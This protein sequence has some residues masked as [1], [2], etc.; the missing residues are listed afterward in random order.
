MKV[1][2]RVWNQILILTS[3]YVEHEMVM[4]LA[5]LSDETIKRNDSDNF[6]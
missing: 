2:N 1:T 4:Q 6:F 3:H 5:S